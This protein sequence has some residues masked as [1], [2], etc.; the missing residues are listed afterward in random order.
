M[1]YNFSELYKF[2]SDARRN[3]VKYANKN[4]QLEKYKVIFNKDSTDE[5]IL[6]NSKQVE[7]IN[8]FGL[9]GLTLKESINKLIIWIELGISD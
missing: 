7:I 9:Q 3:P 8:K 1:K 5:I 4:E 6:M 2:M